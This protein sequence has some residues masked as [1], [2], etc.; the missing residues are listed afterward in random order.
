MKLALLLAIALIGM[1]TPPLLASVLVEPLAPVTSF[2]PESDAALEAA[3]LK[4]EFNRPSGSFIRAISDPTY[5][6]EAQAVAAARHEVARLVASRVR[7]RI[8]LQ[9]R[10][11]DLRWVES[12]IAD[13]LERGALPVQRMLQRCD[14]PY[15]SLYRAA[16]IVDT[17]ESKLQKMASELTS[18]LRHQRAVRL[19]RIGAT[20]FAS[21][22]IILIYLLLNTLTEGYFKSR[23]RLWAA[24]LLSLAIFIV[25]TVG[26]S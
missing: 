20:G 1:A 24:T 2:G 6:T 10:F 16:L 8:S 18:I 15:G 21:V 12:H 7:Q 3:L 25:W 23:L 19:A 9:F 26:V 13:E 5:P 17:P 14:R 11:V 22:G 4:T